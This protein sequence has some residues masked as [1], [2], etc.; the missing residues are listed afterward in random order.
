[1][2][3]CPRSTAIKD[4][5]APFDKSGL[6]FSTLDKQGQ[7]TLEVAICARTPDSMWSSR[8]E[9]GWPIFV[10]TGSTDRRDRMSFTISFFGRPPDFRATI[11]S[12]SWCTSLVAWG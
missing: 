7:L 9:I 12:I 4:A 2:R 5:G 8:C 11:I 10:A 6:A 3:S 1:M